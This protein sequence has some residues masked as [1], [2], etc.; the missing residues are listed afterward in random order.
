MTSEQRK[1]IIMALAN[2]LVEACPEI[3]EANNLDLLNAQKSG[4]KTSLAARLTLNEQ[5]LVT[6][7]HGNF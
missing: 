3:L 5:K 2:N 1:N 7:A 6:L 4:L